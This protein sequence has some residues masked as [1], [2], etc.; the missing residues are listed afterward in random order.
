MYR[1]LSAFAD[2]HDDLHVYERGD[3]YPREGY[4]PTPERIKE[5]S[6]YNNACAIPL[7]KKVVK[8][9]RKPQKK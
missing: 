1:V 4:E 6:G 7:I 3:E 5:L 8:R 9:G 2:A